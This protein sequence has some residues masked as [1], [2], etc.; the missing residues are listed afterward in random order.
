MKIE[1][2]AA[3]H[4]DGFRTLL[5]AAGLGCFCRYWHFTGTKNDW[6]ERSALRPEENEAEQFRD[7]AADDARGLV[8]LDGDVLVGWLKVVPQPAVP[9]LLQQSVYKNLVKAEASVHSIACFLVH[10]EHRER[11]VAR[12]LLQAAPKFARAHGARELQAYPRRTEDRLPDGQA[13]AGP[14]AL[15]RSEG[16]ELL[17][18]VP[19]YPVWRKIL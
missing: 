9:K 4:R 19:P 3:R 18:D 6:L 8:A 1:P 16:Y 14:E 5:E 11:G 15:F 17:H 13:L 2:L 7:P 12:A 10:P